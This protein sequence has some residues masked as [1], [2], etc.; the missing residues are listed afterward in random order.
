MKKLAFALLIFL[1][2][3][4]LLYAQPKTYIVEEQSESIDPNFQEDLFTNYASLVLDLGVDFLSNAPNTMKIDFLKIKWPNTSLYYN[5]PIHKSHFMISPGIKWGHNS[6]NFKD[7][8]T[9]TRTGKEANRPTAIQKAETLFTDSP[10]IQH[11]SLDISYTD[12]VTELRFNA[13]RLEPQDGFFIAVGGNIGVR[14]DAATTIKYQED[15]QNKA[16]IT[17]ESF[18]LNRLRYGLLVRIGWGRFGAFYSHTLSNLFNDKGPSKDIIRP[19]T[20]GITL[21][22]L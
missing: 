1:S 12:F 20:V 9:L 19:F 21:N 17:Q 3:N 5:I 22:L 11:S 8:Y 7:K 18:N 13:N 15:D 10:T 2:P 14:I 6:Y 4:Y 16:R